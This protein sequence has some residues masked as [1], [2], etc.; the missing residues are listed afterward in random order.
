VLASEKERFTF[1]TSQQSTPYER[2]GYGKKFNLADLYEAQDASGE[3]MSLEAFRSMCAQKKSE[4]SSTSAFRPS[5]V[6]RLQPEPSPAEFEQLTARVAKVQITPAPTADA[7]LRADL[8]AAK[9][10]LQTLQGRL[11]AVENELDGTKRLLA[12]AE[13]ENKLVTDDR[14][15]YK[16]LHG[17]LLVK[18]GLQEQALKDLEAKHGLQEQALKD[19]EAKHGLQEQGLKDLEAK[20]GAQAQALTD[21]AEEKKELTELVKAHQALMEKGRAVSA[22]LEAAQDDTERAQIF[23]EVMTTLFQASA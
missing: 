21:L 17:G 15:K 12:K 4:R 18:Y 16:Q 11:R 14:D 20:H 5:T 10:G 2:A 7:D 6:Q 22:R 3:A 9:E 23:G 13:G 8:E 19:L 1:S